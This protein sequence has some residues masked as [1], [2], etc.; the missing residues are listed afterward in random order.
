MGLDHRKTTSVVLMGPPNFDTTH[1]LVDGRNPSFF[2]AAL[3]DHG[4]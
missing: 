1:P 4:L 3:G 2:F